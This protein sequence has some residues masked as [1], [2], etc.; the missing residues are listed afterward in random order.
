LDKVRTFFGDESVASKV[1]PI[2]KLSI[3][4]VMAIAAIFSVNR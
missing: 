1:A 4:F 2:D 3:V